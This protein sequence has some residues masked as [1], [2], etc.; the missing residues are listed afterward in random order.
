MSFAPV[1]PFGGYAGW[2]F[3][4]RT[5]AVQKALVARSPEHTRAREAFQSRAASLRTAEDLVADRQVLGV[6]L[7]AFGLSADLRNKRFVQAILEQG[8][9]E[10]GALAN[11]LSDTRYRQMATAFGYGPLDVR[12][13]DREGFADRILAAY[14]DRVFEEAV[15]KQ[16][17]PLRLALNAERDLKELAE[18]TTAKNDTLWFSVM[19]RPPLRKVF[20][21][22]L[23]LPSSFGRLDIDQQ[24]SVLRTKSED[25]FGVGEVRELAQS[26]KL[27]SLIRRYLLREQIAGS[28]QGL[29]SQSTALSLLQGN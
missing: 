25:A 1:A 17:E 10:P 15:G 22:A 2:Q 14:S 6:A 13:A 20:E 16:S 11:R 18:N 7:G 27:E 24:L 5:E 21:T 23:G 12:G 3:L 19:G 8:T 28:G 29:S 4:K 9:L 26:D